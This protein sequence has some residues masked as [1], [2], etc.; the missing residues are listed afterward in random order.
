MECW[1]PKLSQNGYGSVFIKRTSPG[2]PGFVRIPKIRSVPWPG[3]G[4]VDGRTRSP[5]RSMDSPTLERS[6]DKKM[7]RAKIAQRKTPEKART[8]KD[9]SSK[10]SPKKR[11]QGRW[12]PKGPR[13]RPLVAKKPRARASS[14]LVK[15]CQGLSR[16]A[17]LGP[18]CIRSDM[19]KISRP[20][21]R[22]DGLVPFVRKRRR[23]KKKNRKRVFVFLLKNQN[24]YYAPPD[25]TL[26]SRIRAETGP[27][28]PISLGEWQWGPF[29]G[30]PGR[31]WRHDKNQK[32]F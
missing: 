21:A 1:I 16:N 27:K 31:G 14:K 28:L 5:H 30:T 10:R 3:L 19:H 18:I 7:A 24:I 15:A 12:A 32:S 4:S 11:G 26:G 17:H 9:R 29:H 2:T 23:L 25:L 22:W 8:E 20:H 13:V 6:A